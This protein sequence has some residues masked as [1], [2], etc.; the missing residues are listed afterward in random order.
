ML[1]TPERSADWLAAASRRRS[2]RTYLATPTASAK[3]DAVE[4]LCERFRPHTD[5]RVV[6][7]RDPAI[8]IF[9]GII[10]GYGKVSGAPHALL[11]IADTRS[12]FAQQHLG[13]T[14][15]AAILEATTLELSTCWVGGFFD[16]KR[17]A[18]L[19]ALAPG[20]R[21][22]AVS[23]LGTAAAEASVTERSMTGLAG[24]SGRKA[25]DVLAPDGTDGWPAWATAALETARLAPS[26]V[27]RQPWR[28]RW[29][30]EGLVVAINSRM[31]TPK[32]TKR[33]DCGIA[34]L[35]IEV[36]AAA[37]GVTGSWTDL[38]A[39]LDVARFIPAQ[40]TA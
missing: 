3:L 30:G 12:A 11:F 24:S 19:V 17:A 22:F 2:R 26:A 39:G 20:E 14:G 31:E 6:L 34:M 10:G 5:A 18:T 1:P 40:A 15:E 36:A 29:D 37:F 8:D 25:L 16:P 7:V 38:S 9:K 35:H 32:V 4:A 27:N 21:I 33:L 13:Y 28:F 23:P